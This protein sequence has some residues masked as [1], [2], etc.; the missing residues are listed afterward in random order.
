LTL[1]HY[2]CDHG[3]RGIGGRGVLR[4]HLQPWLEGPYVWLTD[5]EVP[6]REALGLTSH[7]LR[8]DRTVHRYRV[9]DETHA[10][11]WML[12]RQTLLQPAVH[13]LETAPGAMPMHWWVS[14]EP[15]PVVLDPRRQ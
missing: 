1:Y 13:A 6:M 10:R 4:P 2:T 15:V 7:A 9:T 11:R 12:V 3:R 14:A 5:L 8:C